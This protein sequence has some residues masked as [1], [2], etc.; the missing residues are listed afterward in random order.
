MSSK[1]ITEKPVFLSIIQILLGLA[2]IGISTYLALDSSRYLE[3]LNQH[4][5]NQHHAFGLL[6]CIGF[7]SGIFLIAHHVLSQNGASIDEHFERALTR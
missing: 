1:T 6:V 2:L 7:V 4:G 3:V 5:L